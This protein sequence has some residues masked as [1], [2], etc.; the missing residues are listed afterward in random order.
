VLCPLAVKYQPGVGEDFG[1]PAQ[2]AGVV[3]VDVSGDDV[4]GL[5]N[6]QLFGGFLNVGDEHGG[7]GLDYGAGAVLDEVNGEE[8]VSAGNSALQ[9]VYIF[10]DGFKLNGYFFT[11]KESGLILLEIG[12]EGKF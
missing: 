3:E 2:S 8:G 1:Q 10:S 11:S 4:F 6:A 12:G 5:G 7:P 9:A